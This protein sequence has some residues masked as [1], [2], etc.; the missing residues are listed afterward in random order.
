MEEQKSKVNETTCTEM[1]IEAI[2]T[3]NERNG[4]SRQA[5]KNFV[6]SKYLNHFDNLQTLESK[7][8]YYLKNGC[9]SEIFIQPKGP[10]GPIKLNPIL[11]K[12]SKN[13][14][15]LDNQNFGQ[16]NIEKLN[17]ND[18]IGDIV[19]LEQQISKLN[20]TYGVSNLKII[21]ILMT[22]EESK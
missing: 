14:Y 18:F 2:N 22:R 20:E 12:N 3:L 21:N 1:I 6:S 15:K 9:N 19:K 10:S 11:D 13:Y 4:S 5:I 17:V 7:I 16:L 8:N